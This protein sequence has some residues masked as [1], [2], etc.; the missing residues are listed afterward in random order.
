MAKVGRLVKES[1][2]SEFSARLGQQPNFIVTKINRLSAADADILRQKLAGSKARLVV[3]KRTLSLRT[4][5]ELKLQQGVLELFEGSV[6]V[7][8][9]GEDVLPAAKVII[10]FIKTHE[11]HL[12]V[13]GGLVEGEVLNT[14]DIEYL[15]NLPPRPV[16]L[17][18]VLAIIEAPLSGLIFTIEQ[19]IGDVAWIAEQAA[20]KKPAPAPAAQKAEE[21]PK[22]PAEAPPTAGPAGGEATPEQNPTPPQEGAPS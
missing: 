13:R 8:L 9:P 12:A 6:G 18:N 3:V 17:A 2:V 5:Q 21:A 7:V 20:E 1:I 11:E 19:L 10:D 22:A 15:A 4:V 14:S 16:L